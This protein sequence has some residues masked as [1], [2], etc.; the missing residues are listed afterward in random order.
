MRTTNRPYWQL[1]YSAVVAL[2]LLTSCG[3]NPVT[4]PRSSLNSRYADTQPTLSADGRFLALISERNQRQE[5]LLY[6]LQAQQF[7]NLPHL[8]ELSLMPESPSLSASARYLVYTSIIRGRPEVY[9]YD[10][11]IQRAV[12][13][14][15]T[16]DGWVRH[17]SISPEGRYITFETS[18]RGQWDI[19]VIDRG[20]DIELDTPARSPS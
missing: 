1:G 5:I 16:Y 13:L 18:R 19:E 12:S 11:Q 10:R 2:L 6:D 3:G 20:P 7:V 9:L 4:G 8:R 17:P 14:T 15:A